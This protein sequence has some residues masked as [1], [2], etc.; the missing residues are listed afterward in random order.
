VVEGFRAITAKPDYGIGK[1]IRVAKDI[2]RRNAQDLD[3]LAIQP[4]CSPFVSLRPITEVM[5][6]PVDLD[7]ELGCRT[8]EVQDVLT[9]RMLPPKLELVAPYSHPQELLRQRQVAP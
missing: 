7:R 9:D 4:L 5:R 6:N 2:L 8:V 3:V 1:L